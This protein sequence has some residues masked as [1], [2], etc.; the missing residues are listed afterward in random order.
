MSLEFGMGFKS[1][2]G[3]H[4]AG[5]ANPSHSLALMASQSSSI[6]RKPTNHTGL[7]RNFE[8]PLFIC[9]LEFRFLY[10]ISKG[11]QCCREPFCAHR[12][13][14]YGQGTYRSQGPFLPGSPT[15]STGRPWEACWPLRHPPVRSARPTCCRFSTG[16]L[17]GPRVRTPLMT[18]LRIGSLKFCQIGSYSSLAFWPQTS[19]NS[20]LSSA[21]SSCGHRRGHRGDHGAGKARGSWTLG[22]VGTLLSPLGSQEPG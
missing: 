13:F 7:C 5:R 2:L 3:H 11:N 9:L 6:F 19:A 12:G 10:P 22:L 1:K 4:L 21:A 18:L 16:R 20:W 15:A 14:P 8:N 17:A